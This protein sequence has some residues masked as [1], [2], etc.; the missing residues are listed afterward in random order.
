MKLFLKNYKMIN[1]E[2]KKTR[3]E[4]GL[5]VKQMYK[6]LNTPKSTYIHWEKGERRIPGIVTIA[7]FYLKFKN[8]FGINLKKDY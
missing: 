2:L 6:A 8:K 1:I 4:L 3:E 5:T 7:L